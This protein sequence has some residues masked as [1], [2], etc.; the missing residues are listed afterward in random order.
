MRQG[1]LRTVVMW[2]VL[3]GHISSIVLCLV[4]ISDFDQALTVALV[5]LPLTATI[6]MFIVQFNDE[7]FFGAGSDSKIVASNPAYLTI[8]L[9]LALIIAIIGSIYG[10]YTGRIA[11]IELLQKT[12]GLVDSGLAVYLTILL[13]RLFERAQ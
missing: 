6:L 1:L 12:V 13:R 5:L 8:V 10:Y 7:N 4:M 11:T 3:A 9:A 2:L